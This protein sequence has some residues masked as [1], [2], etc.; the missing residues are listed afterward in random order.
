[1]RLGKSLPRNKDKLKTYHLGFDQAFRNAG[2]AVL[3][4]DSETSKVEYVESGF[5]TSSLKM[6]SASDA[7]TFLEH[8]KFIKDTLSRLYNS[9]KEIVSIGVEDVALGAVGQAS[10]RGGIFGVYTMH[11]LKYA[12]LIVVSPKKLKSYVTGDG[13]AEKE[14]MGFALI[15]KYGLDTIMSSKYEGKKAE[16][17]KRMWDEVDAIGIAEVGM[18]AWRI[19]NYGFDSVKDELTPN[20]RRILYSAEPVKKKHKSS[21]QKFFGICNRVNDFYIEKRG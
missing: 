6:G 16:E 4:L 1:M 2:F 5:F 3:S 15:P 7:L 21:E 8:S 14:D 12:D 19:M 13:K 10:A 20:Q 9:G 18:N 17:R 11:A